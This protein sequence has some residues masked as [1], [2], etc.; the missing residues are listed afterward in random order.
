MGPSA[1][2]AFILLLYILPAWSRAQLDLGTGDVPQS[3]IDAYVKPFHHVIASG[4]AQGRFGPGREGAGAEAGFEAGIVPLPDRDPFRTASL[5]AL[6]LLRLR[7]GAWLAGAALETRG[8]IWKDPRLGELSAFGFGVQYGFVPGAF[9]G[10]KMRMD[11]EA[12]WDRL[13]FSSAYTYRYRGPAIGLFDQ[14]VAGDYRLAEAVFGAGATFSVRRGPWSPYLGAGLDWADGHFAYL[15]A[16]PRDGA[17]RRMGSASSFPSGRGALG[18]RWRGFRA[19]AAWAG[20]PAFEA[21]WS[22]AVLAGRKAKPA[23]PV[24]PAP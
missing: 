15:Y 12:G 4:L 3:R 20:Y 7:L 8:L 17:L 2:R 19:E 9:S 6:P 5:S 14:D 23:S 1:V 18:L 21:A 16:D 13:V 22:Y 24:P 11:I 10:W